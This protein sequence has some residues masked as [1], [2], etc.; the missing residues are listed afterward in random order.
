VGAVH[1]PAAGAPRTHAAVATKG[2][3]SGIMAVLFLSSESA[4][5]MLAR[6]FGP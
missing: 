4:V 6:A 2:V 3:G 1:A 5:E